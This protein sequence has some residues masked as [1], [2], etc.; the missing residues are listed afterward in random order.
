MIDD[1]IPGNSP[2]AP[3]LGLPYRQRE[4]RIVTIW[5]ISAWP[6]KILL[7]N[8]CELS[9]KRLQAQASASMR[10]GAGQIPGP[11]DV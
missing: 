4:R 1:R 11:V 10:R 7:A 6:E 3:R 9:L 5:P 8:D 2:A